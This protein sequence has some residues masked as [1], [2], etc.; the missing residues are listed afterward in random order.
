MANP[1]TNLIS[2]DALNVTKFGAWGA[3]LAG[4]V[5]ALIAVIAKIQTNWPAGVVE[6]L[7][8]FAAVAF[9]VMGAVVITDMVVR[10]DLAK[11][12]MPTNGNDPAVPLQY[13][14]WAELKPDLEKVA[15]SIDAIA[16]AAVAKQE[17]RRPLEDI[18]KEFEAIRDH[19]GRSAR[20]TET[21]EVESR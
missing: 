14:I 19:D 18:W 2:S 5:S 11:H 1:N 10:R 4:V 17:A 16:R 8:G 12:V 7:I 6:A 9:V 20:M 13:Q 21:V 15:P 3:A